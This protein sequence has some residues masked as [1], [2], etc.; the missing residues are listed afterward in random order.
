M[1]S[2]DVTKPVVTKLRT[3]EAI[4]KDYNEFKSILA[5]N[6]AH[7]GDMLNQFIAD[8]NKKHGDGN[9]QFTLEQFADPNFIACPAFYRD[10]V[11]WEHYM[12]NANPDELEKLKHQI[13]LI[14][15]KLGRW[16]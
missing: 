12:K 16:L 3:W 1:K 7:V 13:I 11:A 9:D 2:K 8:Y 5:R 14:D 6:G 4:D 15:K 10:G